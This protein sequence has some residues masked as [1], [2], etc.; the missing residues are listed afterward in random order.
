MQAAS[1]TIRSSL[2]FGPEVD[3]RTFKLSSHPDIR[4][5]TAIREPVSRLLSGYSTI[6]NRG[7]GFAIMNG[8]VN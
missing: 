7:G 8:K 1:N 3:L 4:T 5:F 6:T 2:G